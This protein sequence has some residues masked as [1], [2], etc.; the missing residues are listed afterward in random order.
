LTVEI[1]TILQFLAVVA[2]GL[3]SVTIPTYALSITYL[4]RETGS[5][6]REIR[7]R[8]EVL[9]ERLEALREKLVKEG[10]TTEIEAEINR[11]KLE[12]KHLRDR[13]FFLT[14]KGAVVVPLVLCLS[15]ISLSVYGIVESADSSF[16]IL[17]AV[18]LLGALYFLWKTLESVEKAALRPEEKLLPIF[19]IEFDKGG[20][21][22][23][24]HEVQ[25]SKFQSWPEMWER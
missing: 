13:Q 7:R 24:Y 20:Q 25:S 3:M 6:L 11:F 4:A 2:V 14:V 19:K 16:L 21:A 15:C 8:R 1:S 12:E 18:P 10:S 23:T 17:A 9:S 22:L 5:T